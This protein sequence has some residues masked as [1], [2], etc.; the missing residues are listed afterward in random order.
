MNAR[1]C[2]QCGSPIS[3]GA[4]FCQ[5]CGAP[6]AHQTVQQQAP[7]QQQIVY[8]TKQP[9]PGKGFGISSMVMGILSLVYTISAIAM[10]IEFFDEKDN[11]FSATD[12]AEFLPLPIIVVIFGILALAFGFASR[13]RSF[14][15]SSAVS[16]IVMGAIGF[17]AGL[18][19]TIIIAVN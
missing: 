5:K 8:V 6:V 4:G 11:W 15:G 9:V 2:S 19:L 12:K 10:T 3:E 7:V 18:A 16:G 1:F 13:Q 14:K 17:L